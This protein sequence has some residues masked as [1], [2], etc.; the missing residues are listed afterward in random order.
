VRV[1]LSRPDPTRP[2]PTAGW[3]GGRIERTRVGRGF[4][5]LT[6]TTTTTLFVDSNIHH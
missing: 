3:M 5:S 2:D 1:N 4:N 6:T